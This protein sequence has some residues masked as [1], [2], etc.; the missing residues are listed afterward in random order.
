MANGSAP[1]YL[2]STLARLATLAREALLNLGNFCAQRVSMHLL[3][4][5]RV[6]LVGWLATLF[7][8]LFRRGEKVIDELSEDHHEPGVIGIGG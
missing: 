4:N 1:L 2:Y 5:A 7:S 3:K 8:I 6:C